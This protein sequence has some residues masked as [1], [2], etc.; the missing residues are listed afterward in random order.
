MKTTKKAC[1]FGWNLQKH[2]YFG[3]CFSKAGS[4]LS[5]LPTGL[6]CEVSD[7]GYSNLPYCWVFAK[8]FY[9]LLS[10]YLPLHF[11]SPGYSRFFFT[12][13]SAGVSFVLL[14]AGENNMLRNQGAAKFYNLKRIKKSFL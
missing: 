5:S 9:A 12:L 2:V 1:H 3:K 8:I 11:L 14:G 13:I 10:F 7:H 6:A 4:F